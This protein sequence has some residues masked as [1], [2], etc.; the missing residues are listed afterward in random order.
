MGKRSS[1]V[2]VLALALMLA[3]VVMAATGNTAGRPLHA[4]MT[5]PEEVPPGDPDG[6]GAASFTF[7]PGRGRVCFELEV[8]DIEPATL[9]HIHI[10]EAG[11]A[12]PIVVPLTAPTDGSS[13]G[14]VHDVDQ[15]LIKAIMKNPSGY[16]VNV[17]NAEFPPGAV[18]GQLSR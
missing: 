1:I 5:G 17:H 2:L 15:G 10:G 11:V 7:N 16:Y 6:S 13:S 12:G 8:E 4:T 18:R 3:A 14:C 9:A